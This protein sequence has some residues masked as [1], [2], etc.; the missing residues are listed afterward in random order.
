MGPREPETDAGFTP[1]A[2]RADGA[3]VIKS[4]PPPLGARPGVRRGRLQSRRARLALALTGG[5]LVLLC[6]GGVGAFFVLYD[7][8]T[9][10]KR[11]NP[12]AVVNDFLGAYLR[13]RDD[14]AAEL[15]RCTSGDFEKFAAY[16]EDTER[17]E[18]DHSTSISISWAIVSMNVT[19]TGGTV[20]ADVTRTIVGR[21]GRDGSTWQFTV[22]DQD[23][24]R[25]CGATQTA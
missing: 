1:P 17:R 3:A 19:G 6:V 15:Y 21:A 16:R 20:S 11:T 7:E 10:I 18:Q 24:W 25:V 5:F 13:E 4:P 23:G 9:E 8:A 14:K 12:D 2:P 22:V